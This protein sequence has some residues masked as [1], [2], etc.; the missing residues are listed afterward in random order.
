MVV[1]SVGLLLG[2]TYFDGT[3]SW[4]VQTP[5]VVHVE[6][7]HSQD[8]NVEQNLP[9]RHYSAETIDHATPLH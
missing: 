2:S 3:G 4:V 8:R 5:I 9:S 1:R 6:A 7:D